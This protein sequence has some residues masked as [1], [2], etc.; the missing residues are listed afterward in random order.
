VAARGIYAA[1]K[2]ISCGV[3]QLLQTNRLRTVFEIYD[4]LTAA[5]ESFKPEG[6]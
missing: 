5:V 3:H 2:P 1:L 4:D 6:M